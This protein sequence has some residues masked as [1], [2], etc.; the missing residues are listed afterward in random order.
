MFSTVN[1]PVPGMPLLQDQRVVDLPL[2]GGAG[3]AS[4]IEVHLA[5]AL[6]GVQELTHP[7]L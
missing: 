7:G 2:P 5:R 6:E 1:V 3:K 4:R